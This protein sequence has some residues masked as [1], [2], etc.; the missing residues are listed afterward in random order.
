MASAREAVEE[1]LET[2]PV[3]QDAVDRG[4]V[5]ASGLA[6]WLIEHRGLDHNPGALAKHIRD[7]QNEASDSQIEVA[8]SA[9]AEA[10]IQTLSDRTAFVVPRS[11]HVQQRL[12]QLVSE[13]DI[14]SGDDVRL[15][16][17]ERSVFVVVDEAGGE[18]ARDVLG[19]F[20]DDPVEGLVEL[21]IDPAGGEPDLQLLGLVVEAMATAGIDIVGAHGGASGAF[22]L[23]DKNDRFD[24]LRILGETASG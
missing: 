4:I 7:I 3:L 5:N 20:A 19:T 1:Q 14:G 21:R 10:D 11:D 6:E 17:G 13:L 23:V 12:G 15:V 24:A 8:R 16:T 22:V 2:D 9:L 18:V